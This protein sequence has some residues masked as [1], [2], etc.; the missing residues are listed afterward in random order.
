MNSKKHKET[1]DLLFLWEHVANWT[2]HWTQDLKS[3][4]R[5]PTTSHT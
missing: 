4:G 1:T 5:N 2:G 3:L